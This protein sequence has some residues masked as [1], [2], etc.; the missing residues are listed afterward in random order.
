MTISIT[1]TDEQAAMLRRK[2]ASDL[3]NA[4]Y[5]LDKT[6][7]R[8]AIRRG[9]PVKWREYLAKREAW[10]ATLETLLAQ[11]PGAVLE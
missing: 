4:K 8:F 6:R 7:E 5:G 9:R 2:I 11:L 1:L 10:V 3:M